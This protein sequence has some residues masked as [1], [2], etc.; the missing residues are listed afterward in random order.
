VLNAIEN[1]EFVLQLQGIP[2]KQRRQQAIE[3][4]IS[5]GLE[6]R[7]YNR[8]NELSGGQQQR[9]A[10]ARALVGEPKFILADEPTANL[11]SQTAKELLNL[12]EQLNQDKGVT[13]LF[14]THDPKVIDRIQ[15]KIVLEDGHIT[16]DSSLK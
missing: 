16:E 5:V 13:F 8:P 7:L 12:M 1:V 3:T 11:D 9:V 10:I 6:D 2:A 15:R 4:L 14:S